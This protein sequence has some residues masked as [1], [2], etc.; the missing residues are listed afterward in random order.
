MNATHFT[1]FNK[2][3]NYKIHFEIKKYISVFRKLTEYFIFF[4]TL[5]IKSGEDSQKRECRRGI[6]QNRTFFKNCLHSIIS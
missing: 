5:K 4:L 2:C 6:P 3:I 1:H